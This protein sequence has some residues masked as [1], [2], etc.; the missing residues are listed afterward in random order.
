MSG[1]CD[2]AE[3]DTIPEPR[4]SIQ[5]QILDLWERLAQEL[6]VEDRRWLI[7]QLHKIDPEPFSQWFGKGSP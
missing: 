6:P 3:R 2:P 7:F 4:V 5:E 1:F